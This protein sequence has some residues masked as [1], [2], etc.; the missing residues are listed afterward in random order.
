MENGAASTPYTSTF[1]VADTAS[2]ADGIVTFAEAVQQINADSSGTGNYLIEL[3]DDITLLDTRFVINAD[4]TI[5]GEN[6]TIH[7]GTESIEVSGTGTV[8]NLG[9]EDYTKTLTLTGGTGRSI[10]DFAGSNNNSCVLNLYN[11]VTFEDNHTSVI[12]QT[13]RTPNVP[14]INMYGN[15]CIKVANDGCLVIAGLNAN[16]AILNMYDTSCLDGCNLGGYGFYDAKGSLNMHGQSSIK[17]FLD[18]GVVS[19][20]VSM[21]GGSIA[22]CVTAQEK[23]GAAVFVYA[24]APLP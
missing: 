10:I 20:N 3:A 2:A 22:N 24:A 23:D 21:D 12:I 17:N 13:S 14:T 15:S 5:L 8:L 1:K 16:A 19:R 7:F 11:G 6:H 4:T 9:R 18:G